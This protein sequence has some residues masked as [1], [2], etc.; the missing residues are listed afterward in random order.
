MIGSG[1][2]GSARAILGSVDGCRRSPRPRELRRW[3]A[4]RPERFDEFAARYADELE[5]PDAAAALAELREAMREGPVTL[6]TATR[7]LDGSHVT[8]LA[9]LLS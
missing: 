6:V 3:Y 2:V 1:R 9:G 7:D 4:H 8:V 5:S